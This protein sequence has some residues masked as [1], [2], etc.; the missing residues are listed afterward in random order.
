MTLSRNEAGSS[1]PSGP[2]ATILMDHF[3]IGKPST[4]EGTSGRICYTPVSLPSLNIRRYLLS[5]KL[6]C[7]FDLF[8]SVFETSRENLILRF[9]EVRERPGTQFR[10]W[11]MG[12]IHFWTFCWCSYDADDDSS[13]CS[14]QRIPS[15]SASV[16]KRREVLIRG[17]RKVRLRKRR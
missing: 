5:D 12:G 7:P 13:T 16:E 17:R 15:T 3:R 2:T 11:G 9:D 4:T 8:R 10:R 1:E 14:R 6:D